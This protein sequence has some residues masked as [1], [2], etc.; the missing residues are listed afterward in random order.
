MEDYYTIMMNIYEAAEGGNATL[1]EITQIM[2]DMREWVKAASQK[3]IGTK[4]SCPEDEESA[5]SALGDDLLDMF[6][7]F[8]TDKLRIENGTSFQFGTVFDIYQQ[9][10]F[11]I[12]G[13]EFY[14]EEGERYKELSEV[15]MGVICSW[16]FNECPHSFFIK[17]PHPRTGKPVVVPC[18]D[19]MPK[20]ND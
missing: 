15:P 10:V 13:A 5:I 7:A 14:T 2:E 8:D 6:D 19:V 1:G 17:M 11:T 9:P 12:Y 20:I 4:F 18:D 3:I 16:W